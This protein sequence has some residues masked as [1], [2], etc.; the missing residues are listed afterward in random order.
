MRRQRTRAQ[1]VILVLRKVVGIIIYIA[2]QVASATAIIYLTAE[3]DEVSQ[4]ISTN[5]SEGPLAGSRLGRGGVF[6]PQS[7]GPSPHR[8]PPPPPPCLPP[9]ASHPS[10]PNLSPPR[11]P[12]PS[13]PFPSL[14][15]FPPFPPEPQSP[16]A[17]LA[18]AHPYPSFAN[19][20]ATYIVP[21]S[22]TVMNTAMPTFLKK[23]TRLEKWGASRGLG[24][25]TRITSCALRRQRQPLTPDPRPDPSPST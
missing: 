1:R 24:G 22:V 23:L 7:P 15:P 11:P 6:G 4:I 16:P 12:A 20:G 5:L 19:T 21:V 2:L 8:L 10:R 13:H 18:R 3:A 9:R 14:P 25:F 17:P